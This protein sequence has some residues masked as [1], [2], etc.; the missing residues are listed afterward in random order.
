MWGIVARPPIEAAGLPVAALIVV[1]GPQYRV[2]SHRHFVRLARALAR[3]GVTTLRFDYRGMGDTEGELRNFEQT[4]EDI[5]AALRALRA[6]CPATERFVVW[7]LCDA[8]AAALMFATA[9][10]AVIGIVAANP[11]ARSDATLS[12]VHVKH[13]YA[14]RLLQPQFWQ[15]LARGGLDW[16]T[17]LRS[18]LDNLRTMRSR[19][20][21]HADPAGAS[22]FQQRMAAGLRRFR[23]QLLLLVSTDD[24]TA[25]EFVQFTATSPD[26]HGL[27]EGPAVTQISI[28]Q[29]D[30]TFSRREWSE[31]ADA[32]TIAWVQRIAAD[33]AGLISGAT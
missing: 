30:H 4:D 22:T 13:Y 26:W 9:D 12:A 25:M 32:A 24:L 28:A 1:G 3:A 2:G 20:A 17:S 16:R 15:K 8:A 18:L 33:A 6:L 31:Q 14:R 19:P 7:G 21:D 5:H 23:G 10:P 29:A 27:L 11:W